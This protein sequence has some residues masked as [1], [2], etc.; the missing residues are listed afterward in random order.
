[1]LFDFSLSR[2]PLENIRAG[3][4]QYVDPFLSM[5]RPQR[6]DLQAER[7]SAAITLYEMT[8]GV[9]PRWGD[10]QSDPALV[11]VPLHLDAER[12]DPAV[13]D[14]L[15]PFFS[16]A[17]HREVSE[18]F[19]NAEQMRD[20][21]MAA[22]AQAEVKAPTGT[23]PSAE[24]ARAVAA[25]DLDTPLSSLPLGAHAAQ[26]PRS[27][28]CP[29]RAAPA[30]G[31]HVR[32]VGH[33]WR[34]QPTPAVASPWR[35]WHPWPLASRKCVPGPAFPKPHPHG[36]PAAPPSPTR[37]PSAVVIS[38]RKPCWMPTVRDPQRPTCAPCA[39][40]LLGL[41]ADGHPS[42]SAW[43]DVPALE[44]VLSQPTPTIRDGIGLIRPRLEGQTA[45]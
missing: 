41:D 23:A 35:S 34:G 19:D 11:H 13:R 5:R 2:A 10:G 29:H 21:W 7:Y 17:L 42:G 20:A 27:A 24:L 32:G 1:M 26:A 33:A 36:R 16:R 12:F 9:L 25:V 40:A 30:G 8:T 15:T 45:G 22:F 6:W 28:G 38:S 18:R 44:D 4:P 43:L 37:T 3:T 39:R 31:S 14:T